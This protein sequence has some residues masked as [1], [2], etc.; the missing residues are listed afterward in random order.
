MFGIIFLS[1]LYLC[2]EIALTPNHIYQASRQTYEWGCRCEHLLEIRHPDT[3][4]LKDK[5]LLD[6]NGQ[7]FSTI[8][9]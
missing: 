8:K 7:P 4:A 2:A 3:K 5:Q 9:G 6:V 1:L